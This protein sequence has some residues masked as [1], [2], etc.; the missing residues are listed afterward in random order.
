[1]ASM[2]N[3]TVKNKA[4]AD[5]T[6]VASTP[7]AGDS[8][9]ARWTL[10]AANAAIGLRPKLLMVTRDN[11]RKN[12]RVVDLSFSFPITETVNG[13]ETLVATVPLRTQGTL[14]TNVSAAAVADAFIQYGNLLA[15]SLIRAAAEEGF[16]PT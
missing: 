16:A 13:V 10:N 5:V 4:N 12:G 3:I 11:N 9:P 14:P 7:S 1:M 15:S 8:S 6:Y 2:A